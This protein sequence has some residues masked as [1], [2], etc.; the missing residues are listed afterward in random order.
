MKIS[1]SFVDY[2]YR[3]IMTMKAAPCRIVS[4][5]SVTLRAQSL[6]KP[7]LL[8]L[9]GDVRAGGRLVLSSD[10]IRDLLVL[11]LLHSGLSLR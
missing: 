11:R 4:A 7:G 2:H 1:L 10:E 6:T 9:D 5:S 3:N 8:I